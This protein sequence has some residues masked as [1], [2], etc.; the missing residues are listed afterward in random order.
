M[1]WSTSID[2]ILP[3]WDTLA[4][5]LQWRSYLIFLKSGGRAWPKA[6]LQGGIIQCPI[7]TNIM[8][9]DTKKKNL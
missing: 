8:I 5:T 1:F 4:T 3:K 7:T 6:E 9:K 2:K